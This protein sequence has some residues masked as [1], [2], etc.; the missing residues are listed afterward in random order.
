MAVEKVMCASSC[1]PTATAMTLI[2]ILLLGISHSGIV[3]EIAGI[4][5]MHL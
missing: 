2:S 3:V 4:P 1:V 5:I